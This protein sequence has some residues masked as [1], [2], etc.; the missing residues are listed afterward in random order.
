MTSHAPKWNKIFKHR[1]ASLK[2]D[3]TCFDH[4]INTWHIPE[5]IPTRSKQHNS[6][7]HC[8]RLFRASIH[9]TTRKA[10]Q[11]FDPHAAWVV[12]FRTPAQYDRATAKFKFSL[13]QLTNDLADYNLLGRGTPL[14]RDESVKHNLYGARVLVSLLAQTA[15]IFAE[16]CWSVP[17][18]GP[19]LMGGVVGERVFILGDSI[20]GEE[21]PTKGEKILRAQKEGG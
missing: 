20:L 11:A 13:L 9:R 16:E 12:Y 6:S 4:P 3:S 7:D 18:Y 2:T 21:F 1:L 17:R 5:T 14:G 10:I 15:P 8:S 19:R